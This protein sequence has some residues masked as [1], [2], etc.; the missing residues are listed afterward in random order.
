[1]LKRAAHRWQPAPASDRYTSLDVMRGAALF[2]VLMVNLLLAFR[3]RCSRICGDCRTC[4]V[5]GTRGGPAVGRLL[6]FKALTLFSFLFGVGTAIQ[7]ERAAARGIAVT[8]FLLR[9]FA[10]LAAFGI[11]HIVLIWNGDILTLY[12]VCGLLLVPLL[13]LPARLWRRSG[14]RRWCC[15]ICPLGI[16]WPA[17]DAIRAVPRRRPRL[18]TR[19]VRWRS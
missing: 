19:R 5:A 3:C 4:R 7:A 1:M 8:P 9:R 18:R 17:Q 2:G 6:E 11:C 12:A 10:V 16:A 15:R 13:G 14:L